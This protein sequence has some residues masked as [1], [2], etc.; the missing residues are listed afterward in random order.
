MANLITSS[1]DTIALGTNAVEYVS[2][3]GKTFITYESIA[4][5]T[6]APVEAIKAQAHADEHGIPVYA[7]TAALKSLTTEQNKAA[8]ESTLAAWTT[9]N[10]GLF[11]RQQFQA[12][13]AASRAL[14]R[15]TADKV[16]ARKHLTAE[17]VQ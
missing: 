16:Q 9:V 11:G 12:A 10:Q 13:L 7:F 1:V 3:P 2:V 17:D 15:R 4:A 5:L 8:V 6:A 14:R